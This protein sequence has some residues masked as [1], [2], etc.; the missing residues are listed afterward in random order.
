[1]LPE[2]MSVRDQAYEHSRPLTMGNWMVTLLILSIPGVNIFML[3]Y[4]AFTSATNPN[5]RAY[6]QALLMFGLI[7]ITLAGLVAL[8]GELTQ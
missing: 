5:K 2:P 8:I 4:W 1:M 6:C 3:F 7:A